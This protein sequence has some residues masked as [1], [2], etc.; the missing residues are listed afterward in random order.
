MAGT[1]RHAPDPVALLDALQ[2]RPQDFEYFEALRRLECAFPQRPRLGRSARPAEDFVRLGHTAT[3]AFA[4]RDIDR[5]VP[6]ESGRPP[7]LQGLL[8]GLFGPNAPLPLHLTEY[9]IDRQRNAKDPTLAAFADVFHHRMLSLFYRAW[10]DAQP[11]VQADR[12]DEDRFRTYV[13]ALIGLATPY[14]QDRDALPDRYKR[15][16]AG[17]LV[18]QARNA[19]GLKSFLEHFFRIPVR[20]VEFVAAWMPLPAEAHLRLGGGMAGL[21]R[22]AVI[23]AHV[24]GAQQRFRLRLGPMGHAQYRR[25]LP[26]SDASREL[27]AAVRTYVGD[28]KAWEVQLVLKKDEVPLTHLGKAGRLGLSGWLGRYAGP[29]DADALVF[30]PSG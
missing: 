30:E 6:G 26:G 28:E 11:T 12:A 1:T 8:L 3:L 7:R 17:R 24:R 23:G 9:A 14:L 5:L 4:P 13:G 29:A 16:F 18:A 10:A 2:R 20:V 21:G 27:A 19:E 22:T 15:H 25:F